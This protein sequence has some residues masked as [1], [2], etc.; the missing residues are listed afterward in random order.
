[1]MQLFFLSFKTMKKMDQ[2]PQNTKTSNLSGT[3]TL[4]FF[5]LYDFSIG[6]NS[7][8][9]PRGAATD[10]GPPGQHIHSGPPAFRWGV[11]LGYQFSL[12]KSSRLA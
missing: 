8:H 6:K 9:Q 4:G 1:M 12:L 2:P 10:S 5:K 7:E 11:N 3:I